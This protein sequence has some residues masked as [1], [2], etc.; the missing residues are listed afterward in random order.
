MKFFEPPG[1]LPGWPP[2]PVVSWVDEPEPV[3]G[4]PS[5][6]LRHDGHPGVGEGRASARTLA[7]GRA[8]IRLREIARLPKNWNGQGGESPSQL[9]VSTARQVLTRLGEAA[10]RVRIEPEVNPAPDGGIDIA[11]D[12]GGRELG[13]YAAP[14]GVSLEIRHGGGGEP[15]TRQFGRVEDVRGAAKWL[16][17]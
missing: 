12:Y 4:S 3:L 14:D 5:S 13:I 1:G 2:P 7:V 10:E 16:I 15:E 11:C 6:L 17:G 8:L 9:A